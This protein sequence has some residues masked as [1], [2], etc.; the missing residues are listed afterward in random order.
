M[1]ESHADLPEN[2][3][4]ETENQPITETISSIPPETD[5][6][7]TTPVPTEKK[8][9]RK[10]VWGTIGDIVLVCVIVPG[11]NAYYIYEP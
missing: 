11:I 7:A 1:E 8:P 4:A 10:T 6:A 2:F 5:E 9:A 3:T